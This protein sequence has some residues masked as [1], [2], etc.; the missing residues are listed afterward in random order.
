MRRFSLAVGG[1]WPGLLVALGV[2]LIGDLWRLLPEAE[3]FVDGAGDALAVAGLMGGIY[4]WSA[5]WLLLIAAAALSTSLASDPLDAVAALR[6]RLGDM[7][8]GQQGEPG[9]GAGLLS[10]LLCAGLFVLSSDRLLLYLVENFNTARLVALAGTAGCA[11]V[12]VLLW[13]LQRVL[14]ALLTRAAAWPPLR[15]LVH[16]RSALALVALGTLLAALFAV[17]KERT[18]FKEIDGWQLYLPV[19]ALS[20]AAVV[21]VL[22]PRAW[23]ER[24][25][26][27]LRWPTLVTTALLLL[28]TAVGLLLAPGNSR[29]R[30]LVVTSGRDAALLVGF[31]SARFDFDG[32]GVASVLGG[33]DCD[34]WDPFVYPGAVDIPDN[35]VDED[36]FDGDLTAPLELPP[37]AVLSHPKLPVERPDVVLFTIDTCRRD[38]L[39]VYGADADRSPVVDRFAKDAVVFDDAIAASSWTMPSFTAILTSRYAS[40]LPGFYGSVRARKVPRNIELLQSPFARAGYRTVAITA[41]VQLDKLGFDRDLSEWRNLTRGPK[42]N[43]ALPVA[44]AGA[45]LLLSSPTDKPLFLWL[46][47]VDLHHPFEAPREHRKFGKDHRGGYAAELHYVDSVFA[48]VLQ[49]LRESGRDQRAVVVVFS[50]HGEA[51]GEHG[52]EFH[53]ISTYA[54]EVRVPLI[55]RVPGVA[56]R[57]VPE[58]VGLVDLAPTLWDLAGLDSK[59]PVRGISLAPALVQQQALPTRVIFSEQTR[60]T[61]DF[62]LTTPDYRLRYDQSRNYLELFD[63]A[64]DPTEQK[65]LVG[66]LPHVALRLRRQLAAVMAPIAYIAG[67]RLAEVL[68]R[69]IP[70]QMHT[71]TGGFVDG[72][73][74]RAYQAGQPEDRKLAVE[75]VLEARAGLAGKKFELEVQVLDAQ[76]VVLGT[77]K[78]EV[79]QGTYLPG[80]WRSGDLVRHSCKVQLKD[81]PGDDALLCVALLV[82]KAGLAA[83]GG[84]GLQICAPLVVADAEPAAPAAAGHER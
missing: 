30:A 7:L 69:E 22:L 8:R 10:G 80:R 61:R 66:Q 14:A 21:T 38:A 26:P 43:F 62:A 76:G 23:A 39:G 65:N 27:Q 2:L 6:A 78:E 5:A 48:R 63:R 79:T 74:W 54:E 37:A 3:R 28:F 29:A 68:L 25:R 50:D 64:T 84:E 11:V 57:R 9:R 82:D 72:P 71:V 41:G 42:G 34:P 70:E 4:L 58:L 32:D 55:I 60:Y 18:L 59:A 31:W 51:F 15:V 73:R 83:E 81:K 35:G 47:V 13:G 12:G 53:G 40:E 49:A 75:I 44:E 52:A 45:E 17:L 1:L 33:G 36:C 24:L 20:C 56:H 19:L 67:K 77:R 46:H 16:A